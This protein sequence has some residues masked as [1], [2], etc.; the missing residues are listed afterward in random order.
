MKYVN[1]LTDEQI[2]KF[3]GFDTEDDFFDYDNFKVTRYD[4]YILVNF[5][6]EDRLVSDFYYDIIIWD[7]YNDMPDELRYEFNIEYRKNMLEYFGEQYA[8]DYL[9]GE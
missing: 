6:D 4:N 7:E 5:V 8:I 9:L 3:I 2:I 1:K